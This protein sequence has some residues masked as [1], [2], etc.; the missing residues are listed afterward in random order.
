[1][2][3]SLR[4]WFNPSLGLPDY[5]S[6]TIECSRARCEREDTK[7][8]NYFSSSPAVAA[9]LRARLRGQAM[10]PTQLQPRQL[11]HNGAGPSIP[12]LCINIWDPTPA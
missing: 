12:T 4:S 5:T 8:H 11:P 2:G 7:K 6:S 3:F 10:P 9:V 1:M